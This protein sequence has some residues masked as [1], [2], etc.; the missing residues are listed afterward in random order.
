MS[1]QQPESFSPTEQPDIKAYT[2]EIH[3]L[4]LELR[5]AMQD[6][7]GFVLGA[8]TAMIVGIIFLIILI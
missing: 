4:R 6:M 8:V 7:R 2:D 1:N 3:Q 5:Q